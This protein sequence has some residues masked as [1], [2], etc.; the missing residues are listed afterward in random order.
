M[1]LINSELFNAVTCVGC[2]KF[3]EKFK[4]G[5]RKHHPS[6]LEISPKGPAWYN[7][8]QICCASGLFYYLA[9]NLS[10]PPQIM[11]NQLLLSTVP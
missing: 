5:W 6:F 4:R 1:A 9:E 10:M 2:W 8:S 3:P 11:N 7:I